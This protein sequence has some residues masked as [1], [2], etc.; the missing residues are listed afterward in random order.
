[1]G[2]VEQAYQLV[3]PARHLA[4]FFSTRYRLAIDSH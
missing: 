3:C 2:G 4:C 1:L